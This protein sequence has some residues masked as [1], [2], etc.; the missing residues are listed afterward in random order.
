MK[1]KPNR[2][3]IYYFFD[4]EGIVDSYVKF[5]IEDLL[6]H[7]NRLIIV[8]NGYLTN[9]GRETFESFTSEIII[10]D[11]YW[12]NILG[13][14]QGMEYIGWDKL[15][16]YDELIL[17][18]HSIY[19]PLFP[20]SKIFEDMK[21]N[22]CDF[23]SI[24][25]HH[26][27]PH[28]QIIKYKNGDL[29]AHL[30]NYFI[31]F[32][33]KLLNNSIFIQHWRG[34]KV[35]NDYSEMLCQH[36]G[37]LTQKLSNLG[38]K[39]GVYVY[40][41][42]LEGYSY[43]TFVDVTYMLV[44]N[45]NCPFVHKSIFTR[46]YSEIIA[47]SSGHNAIKTLDFIKNKTNYDVSLIYKN[48]IRVSN[49]LSL[50]RN[51][52]LNYILSDKS[53]EKPQQFRKKIALMM[54]IYFSDLID[55][56]FSYAQSMPEYAD[57]YITVVTE[58]MKNE[59]E[60][61]FSNLKCNKLTVII[62][63]NRGRDVGSLLIA[64]REYLYK[65]DYICFM[66]DKKSTQ[67]KPFTVGYDFR[68]KCFDNLLGS[69]AL[70]QNIINT[71]DSNP[72]LGMLMPPPPIHGI[73]NLLMFDEW[74]ENYEQTVELAKRLGVSIP[75][76]R[77]HELISPL[78]TMFWF[79]PESLRKLIDYQWDYNDF[80]VEPNKSDGTILHAIE[81]IYG[82]I[83]QYEG[84]YPAWVINSNYMSVE[85]TNLNYLLKCSYGKQ[86]NTTLSGK[87]VT[88]I[89]KC[90]FKDKLKKKPL[91]RRIA[92]FLYKKIKRLFTILKH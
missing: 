1:T 49:Q 71:F 79:R 27:I 80:P 7:V 82:L 52:H 11:N 76:E 72:H 78:G 10:T 35:T 61:V 42:D 60:A 22:N 84:Y 77:E 50:K 31:V 67:D 48:L 51:L 62:M 8:C 38:F 36:D 34:L 55:Y 15:G 24:T 57:I 12:L 87:E 9:E 18:D 19:G 89:I 91:L 39:S 66:H 75:I 32:R 23:W 86:K 90:Y 30:Q 88:E 4:L 65:Y 28:E 46:P 85:L 44:E 47:K 14:R 73:Y 92:A 63:P 54:H 74:G 16:A 13:Y 58:N 25:K 33:K 45:R 83:V 69:N 37:V 41:D 26:S 81:R 21:E 17:L 6:N 29:P 70:V 43:N 5:I 56:C 68:Y 64:L 2:V 59:V 40:T 3:A 20:F 53:I